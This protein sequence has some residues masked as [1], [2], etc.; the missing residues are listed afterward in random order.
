MWIFPLPCVAAC[1]CVGGG[2]G[3]PGDGGGGGAPQPHEDAHLHRGIQPL[4]LAEA[5]VHLDF[6]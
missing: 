3:A 1:G 4:V 2:G 6:N 5:K